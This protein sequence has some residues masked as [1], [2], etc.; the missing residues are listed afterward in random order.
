MDYAD[1]KHLIRLTAVELD[2]FLYH[3][4]DRKLT[5]IND[6]IV[7]QAALLTNCTAEDIVPHFNFTLEFKARE[8]T[9][10]R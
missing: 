2:L 6:Q 9:E 5:I 3:I 4:R 8:N 1:T 10:E 7:M